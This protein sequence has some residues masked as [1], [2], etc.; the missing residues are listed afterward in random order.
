MKAKIYLLV[1][2]SLVVSVASLAVATVALVKVAP[3]KVA[4]GTVRP[5]YRSDDSLLDTWA[6]QAERARKADVEQ[7]L[8]ELEGPL[9]WYK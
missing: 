6:E 2:V 9:S 1:A 5:T 4:S 8:Q 3:E 7:R